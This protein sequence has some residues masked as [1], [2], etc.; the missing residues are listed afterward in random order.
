MLRATLKRDNG[1]HPPILPVISMFDA[2]RKG[3]IM[4]RE[5]RMSGFPLIPMASA[6]EQTAFRRAPIGTF[7]PNTEPARALDRLWRA[8]EIKLRDVQAA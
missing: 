4:A 5:G 7:A 8:V 2:R 3:H 6:I 1:R